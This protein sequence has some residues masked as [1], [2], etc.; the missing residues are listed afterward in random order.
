[1]SC[2]SNVNLTKTAIEI[3]KLKENSAGSKKVSLVTGVSGGVG[4]QQVQQVVH[5]Q[6]Q[7]VQQPAQQVQQSLPTVIKAQPAGVQVSN[8]TPTMLIPVSRPPTQVQTGA[9]VVNAQVQQRPNLQNAVLVTTSDGKTILAHPASQILRQTAGGQAGIAPGNA[10]VR[11]RLPTKTVTASGQPQVR[12]VRLI[13]PGGQRSATVFRMPVSTG[14]Q[15][16]SNQFTSLVVSAIIIIYSFRSTK[17]EKT[18]T[19][20]MKIVR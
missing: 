9:T 16:D 15:L 10:T 14:G 4:E 5:H 12:Q 3:P 2:S 7:T 1:M 8:Q 13:Q 19:K 11:V 17:N 18:K 6:V 20:K